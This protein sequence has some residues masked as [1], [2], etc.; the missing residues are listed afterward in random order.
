MEHNLA[1]KIELN[2][3]E[4]QNLSYQQTKWQFAPSVNGGGNGSMNFNR[5][6]DQNNQISSGTSYSANYGISASLTLF[7]GFSRLNQISAMKYNALAY[8]KKVEQQENLLYLD[9]L[10][11]FTKTIYYNQMVNY[12]NE[13]LQLTLKEKEKIESKVELGLLSKSSVDEIN[14][15]IS[16][17][18]MLK[19]K[20][21]NNYKLSLLSLAQMLELNDTIE[22]QPSGAEIDMV[23]PSKMD[24]TTMAVYEKACANL[25]ELKMK[26][27]QLKYNKKALRVQQGQVLPSLSLNGGYYS[28]YYSSDTLLSGVKTPF[29]DQFSKYLNPSVGLSLSVPIFN[30]LNNTF[31]IKRSKIDLENAVLELEQQKKT[32]LNQI[33]NTIQQ[34]NASYLEYENAVDNL[35][36]V[37]KSF[38]IFREKYALGLINST[39][40]MIVQNQLMEAKNNVLQAKYSWIIQEKTIQLYQGNRYWSFEKDIKNE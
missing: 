9:I 21:Y 38:E 18:R 22:F 6:T 25:P 15:T 32:I 36:F 7:D 14:A 31:Q 30:R 16:G 1:L 5:S 29:P 2:N 27:L 3:N 11:Q 13:Q 19:E 28:G 33:Q 37:D 10:N 23:L 35:R 34:L 24:Y 39:D 8:G 20:Q 12:A 26:E 40:F 4:K 17:N